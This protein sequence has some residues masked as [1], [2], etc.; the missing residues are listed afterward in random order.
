MKLPKAKRL[1]SGR[2]NIQV[3]VDGRRVS[4]T[5]DTEKEAVALAAA[6][7]AGMAQKKKSPAAMTVGESIDRY[8][9]SKDGVLSPSTVAGYKRVAG[10][11]A[12]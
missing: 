10:V 3:M 1:P 4:L 12:R 2:W 6:Y 9:E 8:I 5:A 11:D 7:K